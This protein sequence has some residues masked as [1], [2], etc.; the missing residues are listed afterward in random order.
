M[1]QT[2]LAQPHTLAILAQRLALAPWQAQT[3]S[4]Y[5][6]LVR[7]S[8]ETGETLDVVYRRARLAASYGLDA[9]NRR[10]Q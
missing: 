9:L 1:K 4:A 3:A 5:G 10:D 2:T 6:A 7:T 8:I